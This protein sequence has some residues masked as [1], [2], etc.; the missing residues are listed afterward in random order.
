MDRV[1]LDANVLFSAAYDPHSRITRL[2]RIREIKLLVSSFVSAEA[3]RNLQTKHAIELKTL[4]RLLKRC[5]LVKEAPITLIPPDVELPMKDYPVLAAAI[6]G[7]ADY[8]L[9]G[10]KHFRSL[11]GRIIGGVTTMRPG[12]YLAIHENS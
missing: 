9:T 8:L 3:I 11:Y 4:Q 7:N 2:W 12:D 1:F 5:E 10:D 6:A